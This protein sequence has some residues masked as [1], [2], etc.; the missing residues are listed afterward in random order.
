MFS[1]NLSMGITVSVRH[2]DEINGFTNTI[3]TINR[4]SP[5]WQAF[6]KELASHVGI[7]P[8]ERVVYIATPTHGEP[9]Y[10][11]CNNSCV[12]VG[13]HIKMIG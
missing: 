6:E 11:W 1:I 9:L 13:T 10:L 5:E 8:G 4:K 12:I 3:M 7:Q 2:I